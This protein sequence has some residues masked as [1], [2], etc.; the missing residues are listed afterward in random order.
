MNHSDKNF[1]AM[2]FLAAALITLIGLVM[3]VA[4]VM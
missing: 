4:L 2:A 3:P 1:L